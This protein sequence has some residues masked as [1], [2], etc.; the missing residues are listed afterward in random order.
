MILKANLSIQLAKIKLLFSS[1]WPAICHYLCWFQ[2][3]IYLLVL[4]FNIPTMSKCHQWQYMETPAIYIVLYS[5]YCHTNHKVLKLKSSG[6]NCV[7]LKCARWPTP[8]VLKERMFSLGS[9]HRYFQNKSLW[10]L[11]CWSFWLYLY[12]I[13]WTI[14]PV[15]LEF[16]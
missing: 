14:S 4:V 10:L 11:F 3:V 6:E 8:N 9:Q 16:V 5:S 2:Y 1:L 7:K 15:K 13:E 12:S